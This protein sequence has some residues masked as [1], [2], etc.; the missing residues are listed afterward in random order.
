[1]S[2]QQSESIAEIAKALNKV[3]AVLE[4]VVKDKEN[5]FFKS[6]YA[7]LGSIWDAIRVPLAE[8][9]LSVIQL[10]VG[11]GLATT[12]LHNT[13]GEWISGIMDLHYIPD[14][15]GNITPQAQGSA[16]KYARRYALEALIGVCS[17]DDDGEGAM[18]R[19][20]RKPAATSKV[21]TTKLLQEILNKFD[22]ANSVKELQAAGALYKS[23]V[24]A[25]NA[26]DKQTVVDAYN[27]AELDLEVS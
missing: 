24:E 17:I 21:D 15:N 18:Q 7:D 19:P 22:H 16:I 20:Q 26:K 4:P 9:G 1:M 27:S 3:Q 25:M 11:D 14:K 8:N 13:S 10:P 23:R 12:L 5:P 2:Y 6:K